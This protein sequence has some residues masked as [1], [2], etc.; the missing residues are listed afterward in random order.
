MNKFEGFGWWMNQRRLHGYRRLV[1]ASRPDVSEAL[2]S[3]FS[4]A[5][6]SMKFRFEDNPP[7]PGGDILEDLVD[8]LII[9]K[10]LNSR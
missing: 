6:P 4:R 8:K 5:S 7:T 10:E 9:I 3:P 1:W 2:W